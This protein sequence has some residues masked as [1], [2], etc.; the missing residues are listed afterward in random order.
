M[1]RIVVA[2]DQALIRQAFARL[3]DLESDLAVVGEASSADEAVA[4]AE[5]TSPDV[6]VMDVQMPGGGEVADGIDATAVIRD[7]VPGARVIIVTTFGRPG[8]LQRAMGAGAAGFMVKD[9]PADQLIEGIRRVAQGLRVVDPELAVTSL[10]VGTSPLTARETEVLARAAVGG[11]T[12]EIASAVFLSEGT[13]RNHLSAAIT[14]LGAANRAE[15]VRIATDSG[16][17]G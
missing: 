6:V 10:T 12:A 13:V 17:I 2:D 5:R 14:K 15:A 16:W 11:T 1:I 3:L 4:V 7:R 8:Y 9:A